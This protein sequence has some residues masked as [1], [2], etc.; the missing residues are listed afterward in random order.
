VL[1]Y[2][3]T[4]LGADCGGLRANALQKASEGAQ[5]QRLL[6][7][8]VGSAQAQAAIGSALQYRAANAMSETFRP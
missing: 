6:C 7:T 4:F 3:E 5:D 1:R 2:H 8:L